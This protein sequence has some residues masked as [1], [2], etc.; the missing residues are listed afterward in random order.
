MIIQAPFM[1]IAQTDISVIT[2]ALNGFPL[3]VSKHECTK[4]LTS[5]TSRYSLKNRLQ[6]FTTELNRTVHSF[7]MFDY[8]N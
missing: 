3:G 7:K 2:Q 1:L 4:H 6:T 5:N 8:L